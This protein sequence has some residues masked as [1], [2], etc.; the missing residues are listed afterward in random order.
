MLTLTRTSW[1][2]PL[3]DRVLTMT[4]VSRLVRRANGHF[5]SCRPAAGVKGSRPRQAAAV[6]PPTP[7]SGAAS[8][9]AP[10]VLDRTPILYGYREHQGRT[11]LVVD[12][13]AYSRR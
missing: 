9:A 6:F 8:P 10:P 13:R 4:D 7:S 1:R 11:L 5:E 2:R 3:S 12:V